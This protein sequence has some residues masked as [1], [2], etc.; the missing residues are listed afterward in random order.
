MTLIELLFSLGM[1]VLLSGSIYLVLRAVRQS[2]TTFRNKLDILQTTRLIMA[3][4]RNELRN[5]SDK[6][7][8]KPGAGGNWYLNIP[9][10]NTKTSVYYFDE[11]N[12]RLYTGEKEGINSADPAPSE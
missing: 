8:P 3:R 4:I 10:S 2:F 1:I 12:R 9:L 5:A 6:P 7:E 11:P